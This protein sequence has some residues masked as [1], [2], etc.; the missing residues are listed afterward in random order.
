MD[1]AYNAVA[2]RM[3]RAMVDLPD[4]VE[5]FWIYRWSPGDEPI[6][7]GGLLDSDT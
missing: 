7:W 4:D 1:A 2:D 6:L 5:R 3:E